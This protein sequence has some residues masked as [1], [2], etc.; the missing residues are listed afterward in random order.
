MHPG[1][2]N[3][4]K[5]F[6]V[7]LKPPESTDRECG[8]SGAQKPA[9]AAEDDDLAREVYGVLGMPI[10]AL[11]RG[12]VLQVIIDAIEARRPPLPAT[13]DG[14]LLQDTRRGSGFSDSML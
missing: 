2:K 9:G 10:D 3:C 8:L 12:S 1:G 11:D 7:D 13:P 14:I 5:I 6:K 4:R